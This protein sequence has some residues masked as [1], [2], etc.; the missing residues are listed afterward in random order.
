L[1]DE[2]RMSLAEERELLKRVGPDAM[3]AVMNSRSGMQTRITRAEILAV[4][5]FLAEATLRETGDP[6]IKEH[7]RWMPGFHPYVNELVWYLK[8]GNDGII[9]G[10]S[11][12]DKAEAD[13]SG[14]EFM[15]QA[16]TA[17]NVTFSTTSATYVND[18]TNGPLVDCD[19][20]VDEPIL[21]IISAGMAIDLAGVNGAVMSWRATHFSSGTPDSVSDI[22]INGCET[23]HQEWTPGFK[24]TIW[25]PEQSGQY[26]LEIVY[27]RIG[28]TG[29][30]NFKNRRIQFQRQPQYLF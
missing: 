24:T 9:L 28:T 22:N 26:E 13:G 10:S 19:V 6:H 12:G 4:N 1:V 5:W 16:S 30:A 18:P 27:K 14:A 3:R 11:V 29:N 7:V 25:T 2:E 23:G 15:A 21:I 17:D 8:F 20:V